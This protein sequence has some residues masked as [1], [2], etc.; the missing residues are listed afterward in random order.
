MVLGAGWHFLLLPFAARTLE[1]PT[2][3]PLS[4]T[5]LRINIMALIPI[6]V[7][8]RHYFRPFV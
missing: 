5:L 3:P 6:D 7:V 1:L 4:I 2:F 8:E